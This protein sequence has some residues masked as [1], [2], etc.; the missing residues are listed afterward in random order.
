MQKQGE[1]SETRIF[2]SQPRIRMTTLS[3]QSMATASSRI[4]RSSQSRKCQRESHPVSFLGQSRSSLRMTYPNVSRNKI[5]S[6]C[7]NHVK[8]AKPFGKVL[9]KVP[10]ILIVISTTHLNLCNFRLIYLVRQVSESPGDPHRLQQLSSAVLPSP[11][12]KGPQLRLEQ[13]LSARHRAYGEEI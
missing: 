11:A 7:R 10:L 5:S 13:G 4:R 3:L 12:S 8:E 6:T 1:H 2:Q 9:R